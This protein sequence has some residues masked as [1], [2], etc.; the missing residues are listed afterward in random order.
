MRDKNRPNR[1]C[2]IPVGRTLPF[3]ACIALSIMA[4]QYLATKAHADS[5]IGIHSIPHHLPFI[6]KMKP[7]RS[8][9]KAYLGHL[10]NELEST[11]RQLYTSQQTCITLRRRFEEQRKGAL[12]RS[13]VASSESINEIEEDRLKIQQQGEEIKLLKSQLELETQKV[14]KQVEQMRLLEAEL[15]EVSL[16][17]ENQGEEESV[18][19][20]KKQNEYEQQLEMLTLKLE[21]AELAAK[22]QDRKD[23]DQHGNN[24]ASRAQQLNLELQKVRTRYAKLSIQLAKSSGDG[25]GT[26][27]QLEEVMDEA[28]QT[29]VLSSLESI[30][31]EWERKYQAL[32]QQLNNLNQYT[33]R[34]KDERD[35]AKNRLKESKSDMS[36]QQQILRKKLTEELTSELTNS[37]TEQLKVELTAKIEKRLRRKYKKLQKEIESKALDTDASQDKL[38]AADLEKMK[39]QYE[40]EY[41][42]KV[43]ELKQQNEEQMQL[44][45]E[46]MRKLVR[47]LLEREAK[48]KKKLALTTK[49][50]SSTKQS[51]NSNEMSP[52]SSKRMKNKESATDI[53]ETSQEELYTPSMS[54]ST[55]RKRSGVVPVRGNAVK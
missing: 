28:I 47:A 7:Y 6:F 25:D 5:H 55:K 27:K 8:A 29:A 30:E 36:Q 34:I 54:T 19:S 13:T 21:A 49:D 4:T 53:R 41:H 17:K 45:K 2:K 35:E 51:S 44:Q 16:W 1:R 32:E 15:K 12:A 39:K 24:I 43:Q 46:R 38:F 48:D 9:T 52:T 23:S 14:E 50:G 37:I 42:L 11:Q 22:S 40:A 20:S 3:W 18:V 33:E 26:H 10:Q 31:D